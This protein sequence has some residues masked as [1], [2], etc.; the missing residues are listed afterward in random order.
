MR[1]TTAACLAFPALLSAQAPSKLD[2]EVD[3]RAHALE[4]KV[5]A[6][7]RDIHQHPELGNREFRT[8]K[9]VAEHLQKL[10]LEVKTGVAKT[11]VVG[12]LRGGKPGP[13][14]ALRADMD[15]LPVAEEVDLPFKST[16]RATYNGQDVGVMH[17]CGHDNHVAILMGVAE[18]LSGMKSEVQGTVVFVFQPAEEGA[19]AGERGGAEVMLEEGIFDNPKVD[20]VFGLHVFPFETGKIVYRSGGLMASG[21]TYKVVIHGRQTHGALPWNGVDPI[22]I[23]SQI[24]TSAQSIVSRQVD[25]TLTPA[26]VTVGYIRGGVR[27]NIIP[28]SVEFGGTIRT[29]DETTRDSI[30]TKFTRLITTMAEANG[31]KAN[32][33]FDRGT[34]VTYNDPAL[35]EKMAPSLRRALG[36]GQVEVGRQTTTSEDYSLYQK[37]VPGVFYFL[38]VTPKGTDP[39]KIAPNHSPRFFAD[40]AALVPGVKAL[41]TLALDY[42]A[43]GAKPKM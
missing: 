20:A 40:E 19:P 8:S 38:G 36:A 37:K 31:A 5:V 23:A 1:L 27:V 39:A 11:G 4:A 28:D 12:I 22:T 10:G 35:T 9:L 26:I 18:L 33:T 21:D 13:V 16:V 17:A 34:P 2:T 30:R 25:L 32:I 41:S 14:V 43:M 7:R 15:A 29:F 42:L 6:W 3:K 24:I